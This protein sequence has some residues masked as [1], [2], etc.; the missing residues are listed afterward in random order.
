MEWMT[1][2]LNEPGSDSIAFIMPRDPGRSVCRS[3]G[4]QTSV[5]LSYFEPRYQI[6][7]EEVTV[8][9]MGAL[10]GRAG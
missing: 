8:T 5:T 4:G 1:Q 6:Y 2:K 7:R 10:G 3:L 9:A